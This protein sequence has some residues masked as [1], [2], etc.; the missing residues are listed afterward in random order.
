MTHSSFSLR[1][2]NA[3]K[4][5]ARAEQAQC[6]EEHCMLHVTL[7]TPIIMYK[8]HDDIPVA[9]SYRVLHFTI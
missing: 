1:A 8:Y 5:K 3:A 9:I 2:H 7:F 6:I 4:M